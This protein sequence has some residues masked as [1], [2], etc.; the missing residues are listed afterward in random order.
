MKCF[1][2][3]KLSFLARSSLLIVNAPTVFQKEAQPSSLTLPKE[4]KLKIL[5]GLKNPA[6][7]LMSTRGSSDLVPIKLT[8][9][10]PGA[11]TIWSLYII[12]PF[13][14]L[15]EGFYNLPV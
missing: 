2:G 15:Y 11:Q 1:S 8:R 3:S 13:Y 7:L 10:Q 14:Q 5:P 9:L 6:V 12:C 4:L